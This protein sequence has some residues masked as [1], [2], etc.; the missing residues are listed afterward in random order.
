MLPPSAHAAAG[1]PRLV[2]I[3]TVLNLLLSLPAQLPCT[4]RSA[5]VALGYS[6]RQLK[7]VR[8][9]MT[10]GTLAPETRGGARQ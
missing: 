1:D 2:T 6:W 4:L 7:H 5:C 10:T 9:F 8:R 3:V